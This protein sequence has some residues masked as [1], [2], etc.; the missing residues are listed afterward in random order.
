[1]IMRIEGPIVQ[2]TDSYIVIDTNGVGYKVL[3]SPQTSISIKGDSASLWTHMV[4]RENSME[5][6]GFLENNELSFFEMLIGVS[7]VGPRSALL[8]TAVAS[9]NT[10]K[11]AIG[12]GDISHLTK[13]SGIGKKTAEK[14]VIELRDKLADLGF[15]DEDGSLRGESDVLEALLSLGYS[16]QEA[17][18][19]IR[20][21][22][23]E[24][25]DINTKIKEALKHL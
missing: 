21:I 6:F 7:G 13:V 1:M 3:I 17:R 19:A 4:V 25:T 18:N 9:I 12:S 16:N 11:K 5:L 22:P 2:R 23:S 10:L 14:V 8:I 15:S 24:A 20:N